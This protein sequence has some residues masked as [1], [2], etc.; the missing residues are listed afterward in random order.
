LK[1]RVLASLALLWLTGNLACGFPDARVPGTDEGDG[2]ATASD[3]PAFDGAAA[4]AAG[5]VPPLATGSL[6]VH[7]LDVGQGD[8]IL[9]ISP[10][11]ETVL[12]DGGGS[13]CGL[14]VQTLDALGVG[15]L[16]YTIASHYHE[17]HIGCAAEI[18]ARR[19]VRRVAYDRGASPPTDSTGS[20]T[21]DAYVA[22]V[23]KQRRKASA[24]AP[25]LL[26]GGDVRIDFAAVNG[27]GTG[28]SD[29]N[30]LSVVAVLRYGRF[31]AVMG[32]D[33]GGYDAGDGTDVETTV[34]P[35]VG[36]VEV[37]KV[38]HHG[39]EDGSNP[40][41]LATTQPLVGVVPVG[42]VNAYGHPSAAAIGRLHQAGVDLY[43]TQSGCGVAPV[44]DLDR[45]WGSVVVEVPPGSQGFTVT[46]KAGTVQYQ[47]WPD[48]PQAD[49]L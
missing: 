10:G 25:I 23:G 42:T 44:S 17:D 37:Y 38:H 39:S 21:Y 30:D 48:A 5:E 6:R 26:D 33:L 22:A 2:A 14:V 28:A 29:E 12:V 46:G 49:S 47:T 43:W 45:V 35:R 11:G 20:D 40:A 7:F 3:V 41:W 36:R 34:A 9:V 16:D 8:A 27:N 4:D 19:D 31:D 32:G 1:G 15:D 24:D 18:L 13:R